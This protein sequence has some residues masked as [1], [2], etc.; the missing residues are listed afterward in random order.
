MAEFEKHVSEDEKK[1]A[2]RMCSFVIDVARQAVDR[3]GVFT[4]GLSGRYYQ[5]SS[6]M[7]YGNPVLSARF[8]FRYYLP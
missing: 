2:E 4:V 5:L 3:S 6:N 1:V 8:D 7:S